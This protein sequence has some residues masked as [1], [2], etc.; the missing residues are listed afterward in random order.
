MK[1]IVVLITSLFIGM[2]FASAETYEK[3][4]CG[5]TA[6]P[7]LAADITS[8]VIFIIQ[9]VVPIL[10][11]VLG[12]LDFLKAVASQKEDEIKKGFPTFIKRLIAGIIVFFVVV[13]VK[14]IIGLVVP[15][16][17]KTSILACTDCFVTG[18]CS[19]INND[20][21]SDEDNSNNDN[22]LDDESSN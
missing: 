10:I 12:S 13:I 1:K 22:D 2:S 6:F 9:L 7:L 18:D 17:D 4:Q 8:T 21:D 5:D 11:V 20:D 15:A 19:P 3:I 14:T 16:D